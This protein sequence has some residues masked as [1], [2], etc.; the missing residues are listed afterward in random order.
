LIDANC[1]SFLLT[2]GKIKSVFFKKGKFGGVVSVSMLA[3]K[4]ME[5]GRNLHGR[6]LSLKNLQDLP[7]LGYLLQVRRR[8][9]VGIFRS[10]FR[11]IKKAILCLTKGEPWDAK[12]F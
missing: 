11:R 6:Y 9:E 1:N 2:H 3:M 8:W 7:F 10:I 4:F 5:K 12:G